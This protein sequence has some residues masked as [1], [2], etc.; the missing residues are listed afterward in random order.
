MKILFDSSTLIAASVQNH[1]KH[2]SAFSWLKK[3][4][5]SEVEGYVSAH[6]LLEVYS[7]LTRTPFQPK[8]IPAHARRL[9]DTN[10]TSLMNVI[11]LEMKGYNEILDLLANHQLKGGIVY[12]A[13]ILKCS[14]DKEIP[15][16]VTANRKDFERLV[17]ALAFKI[18]VIGI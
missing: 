4:K 11:S 5:N 17:R 9:I 14:M 12:D 13:L 16:I 7:V 10:V 2:E 18:E 8:I 15:Y 6:T 1:P 3:A